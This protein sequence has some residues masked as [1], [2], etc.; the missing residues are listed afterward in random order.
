MQR[1]KRFLRLNAV[2]AQM[3]SSILLLRPLSPSSS[4]AK[5]STRTCWDTSRQPITYQAPFLH[6]PRIRRRYRLCFR[7]KRSHVTSRDACSPGQIHPHLRRTTLSLSGRLRQ[8]QR[9]HPRHLR[10]SRLYSRRR[11]QARLR[12]AYRGVWGSTTRGT[13]CRVYSGTHPSWLARPRF[14]RICT[15]HSRLRL[16]RTITGRSSGGSR[17]RGTGR[18][19]M[20]RVV[21]MGTMRTRERVMRK[22]GKVT[23]A[24]KG[25]REA[26][27]GVDRDD[28]VGRR[29]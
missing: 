26:V 23:R 17:G 10:Q 7:G 21:W 15:W 8:C 12:R 6:P 19:G 4:S 2:L 16:P 1:I 11:R 5:A 24:R 25:E 14:F 22:E 20:M 28:A 29:V 9:R 18:T 13:T 3:Y 27:V